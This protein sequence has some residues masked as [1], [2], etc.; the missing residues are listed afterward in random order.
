MLQFSDLIPKWL[1][2]CT[3]AEIAEQEIEYAMRRAH[4]LAAKAVHFRRLSDIYAAGFCLL[5]SESEMSKVKATP[6]L[7]VQTTG[8]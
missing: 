2:P 1:T 7:G 3:S 6:S 4:D 8:A 5:Q